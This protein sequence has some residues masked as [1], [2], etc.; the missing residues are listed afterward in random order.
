MSYLQITTTK[1]AGD[2][3]RPEDE[4]TLCTHSYWIFS[5]KG[6][7]LSVV[8]ETN[9]WVRKGSVIAQ[10]H[11]VFGDLVKEYLAPEVSFNKK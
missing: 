8:P 1:I 3:E 5:D 4:P 10:I 9:T 6:G 2:T 11:S 7:L